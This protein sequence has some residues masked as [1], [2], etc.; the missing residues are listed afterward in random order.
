[1][2]ISFT[3]ICRYTLFDE[4]MWTQELPDLK[5]FSEFQ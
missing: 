3:D 5:F 4:S 2:Q 1:M